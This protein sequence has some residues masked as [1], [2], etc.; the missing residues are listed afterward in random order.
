MSDNHILKKSSN[1]QGNRN[2]EQIVNE[3]NEQAV[4]D[5]ESDLKTEYLSDFVLPDIKK[6]RQKKRK[7][8]ETTKEW[9]EKNKKLKPNSHK[10]RPEY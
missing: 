1:D 8:K 4:N 3:R 7:K 9:M 6:P 10:H 5:F 2:K